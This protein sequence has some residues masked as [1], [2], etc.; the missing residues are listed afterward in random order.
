MEELLM[1]LNKLYRQNYF[2]LYRYIK[3]NSWKYID[4]TNIDEIINKSFFA[5]YQKQ[6]KKYEEV[7]YQSYLRGFAYNIMRNTSVTL[8]RYYNR[9]MELADSNYVLHNKKDILDIIIEREKKEIIHSELNILNEIEKQIIILHFFYRYNYK[10]ISNFMCI[11]YSKIRYYE[12]SGLTQLKKYLLT[13][14]YEF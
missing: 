13:L 9:N 3:K 1:D 10:E 14:D 4:E 2:A 12:K 6:H 11:S 5:F 8:E 7:T